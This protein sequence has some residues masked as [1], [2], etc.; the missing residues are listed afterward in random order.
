VD[1]VIDVGMRRVYDAPAPGEG[2]AV[3]ID[4]LWPRGIA[5]AAATWEAWHPEVAPSH[6]LR[7]WYG[8]QAAL[9]AE[10][11]RRY[12][13]ELAASAEAAAGLED[14]RARAAAAGGRL[15]LVTSTR[16]PGISHAEVLRRLLAKTRPNDQEG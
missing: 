14:L 3:L 13:A 16:E 7:R 9:F 11:E 2:A 4:R 6:A 8:H 10:F 15:T 5:R 12:L 1:Q